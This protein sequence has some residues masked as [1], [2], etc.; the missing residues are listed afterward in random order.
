MEFSSEFVHSDFSSLE[1]VNFLKIERSLWC[2]TSIILYFSIRQEHIMSLWRLLQGC[3]ERIPSYS[4]N[5]KDFFYN[6]L[7][8]WSQIFTTAGNLMNSPF[9]FVCV[10]VDVLKLLTILIGRIEMR[11]N[12]QRRDGGWP[13]LLLIIECIIKIMIL[14]SINQDLCI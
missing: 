9:Y 12:S 4:L 14:Q 8:S 10:F 1:S 6:L 7:S 3:Q 11:G 13:S 2:D 5:W